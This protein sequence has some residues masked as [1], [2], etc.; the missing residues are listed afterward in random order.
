MVVIARGDQGYGTCPYKQ[1]FSTKQNDGHHYVSSS[2]LLAVYEW[3]LHFDYS[4]F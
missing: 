2:L 4:F 1:C 3:E